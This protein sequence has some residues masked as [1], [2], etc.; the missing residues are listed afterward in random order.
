M[1]EAHK[2][3]GQFGVTLSH[4]RRAPWNGWALI[5]ARCTLGD[6][7]WPVDVRVDLGIFNSS[8]SPKPTEIDDVCARTVL[9]GIGEHDIRLTDIAMYEG[10]RLCPVQQADGRLNFAYRLL[11]IVNEDNAQGSCPWVCSS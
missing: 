6:G 1:R 5:P 4:S 3:Y 7:G 9:W 10:F 11:D 2:Y 8:L